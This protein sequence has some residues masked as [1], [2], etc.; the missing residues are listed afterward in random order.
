MFK[1]GDRVRVKEG[2]FHVPPF[3]CGTVVESA[4]GR[5]VVVAFDGWSDGWSEGIDGPTNQWGFDENILEL[6]Q[7]SA[8]A[9]FLVLYDDPMDQTFDTQEAAEAEAASLAREDLD[10]KYLILRVVAT[11]N[12]LITIER[13]A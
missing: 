6:V 8:P 3:T 9:K 1:V 12:A 10:A 4:A 2:H 11:V 13:A 7:P 5:E